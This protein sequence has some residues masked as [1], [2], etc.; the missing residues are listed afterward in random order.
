MGEHRETVRGTKLRLVED[1]ISIERWARRPVLLDRC[2]HLW[3]RATTRWPR[4]QLAEA[5]AK[6]GPRLYI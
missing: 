1:T 3:A 4:P 2:Q 6:S 5:V